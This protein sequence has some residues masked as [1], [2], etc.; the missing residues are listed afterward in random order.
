[1]VVRYAQAKLP[2]DFVLDWLSVAADEGRHF[3]LLADRLETLDSHYGALYA[4]DGLWEAAL[5][6]KDDL[7]GRLAIAPMVLEARGLDVTPQLIA[8]MKGVEDDASADILQIIM[9]D[10][11]GHV[12]IGKKWFDY[13]CGCER[14]DPISTWQQLVTRYFRGE[15]KPPFNIDARKAARFSAAFYSPLAQGRQMTG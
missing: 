11:V 5:K 3:T 12:A 13:V 10:E 1:M 2:Y 6:T 7:P 9:T 8:K 15:L 14:L 4:H